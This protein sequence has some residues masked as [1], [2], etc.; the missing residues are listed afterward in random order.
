MSI[1][2]VVGPKKIDRLVTKVRKYGFDV[3]ENHVRCAEKPG[4]R[5][6][7]F[8]DATSV[9]HMS[10]CRLQV[11]RGLLRLNRRPFGPAFGRT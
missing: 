7:A 1:F 6:V 9:L 5:L 4:I 11:N 3:L 8:T 2:R 10:R